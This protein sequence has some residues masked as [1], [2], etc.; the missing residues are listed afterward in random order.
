LGSVLTAIRDG[1]AATDT[2][3]FSFDPYCVKGSF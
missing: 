1:N 3:P 2:Q